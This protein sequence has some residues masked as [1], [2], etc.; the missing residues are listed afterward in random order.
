MLEMKL[1]ERINNILEISLPICPNSR[2][3]EC[4]ASS[5]T[6]TETYSISSERH[7]EPILLSLYFLKPKNKQLKFRILN[8]FYFS[9]L[10]FQFFFSVF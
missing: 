8:S 10:F 7:H 2:I 5:D 1:K 4:A 3:H 6:I 9:V